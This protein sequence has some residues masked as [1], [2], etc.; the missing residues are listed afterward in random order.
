[1]G[2]LAVADQFWVSDNTE[3]TARLRIQEGFAQMFPAVTMESW[4]TDQNEELIPLAFRF[5]ASMCGVL[6]VG[7]EIGKWNEGQRKEAQEWIAVYKKYR[8]I[9]HWGDRYVLRSALA[10]AMS[11]VL[12]VDKQKDKAVLFAFRTYA[13]EPTALPRVYLRGLDTER[14]YEID[15]QVKSGAAW[16]TCG[17]KMP[18]EN[19]ESRMVVVNVV[20]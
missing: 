9:I 5:H 1:M 6:G 8:H 14:R 2:V 11:A 3:A 10:G 19:F 4:V 7:G 20:G 12:Y 18:L 17:M 15:G 16:G 13:S